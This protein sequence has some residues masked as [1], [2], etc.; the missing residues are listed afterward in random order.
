MDRLIACARAIDIYGSG[1]CDC[2]HKTLQFIKF[3]KETTNK[4]NKLK[5]YQR[6]YVSSLDGCYLHI[7]TYLV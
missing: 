7:Y 3:K 4:V 6:D 2:M 5:C 1:M